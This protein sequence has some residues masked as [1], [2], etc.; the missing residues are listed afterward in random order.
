MQ[1]L[2]TTVHMKYFV[3]DMENCLNPKTKVLIL[4]SLDMLRGLLAM[5]EDGCGWEL[6]GTDV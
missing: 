1:M 2:S 6:R 5:K 4:K 3:A